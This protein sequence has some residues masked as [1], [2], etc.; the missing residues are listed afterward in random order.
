[1]T[2]TGGAGPGR[3]PH[4][5]QQR[6]YR[7]RRPRAAVLAVLH[8]AA[9]ETGEPTVRVSRKELV[10]L[11]GAPDRT[12][13]RVLAGLRAEGVITTK[14][15]LAGSRF[16]GLEVTL[17]AWQPSGETGAPDDRDAVA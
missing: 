7:V 8:D 6:D 17:L 15:T 10:R 1:M 16:A 4:P 13:G 2:A 12:V 11:T 3:V 14:Q 9:A 5:E